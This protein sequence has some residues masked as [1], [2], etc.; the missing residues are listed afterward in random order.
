MKTHL[1]QFITS[2]ACVFAISFAFAQ[3][4]PRDLSSMIDEKA[5]YLEDDM[6]NH[7]YTYIKTSKSGY[8]SYTYWWNSSSNK[9]VTARTTG[10][11][12]ASITE[13]PGF[14]CGKSTNAANHSYTHRD[15]GY[16]ENH[17][18]DSEKEAYRYG[19]HDGQRHNSKYEGYGSNIQ[20]NAYDK[21]YRAGSN[22]DAMDAYYANDNYGHTHN[23]YSHYNGNDYTS[24]HNNAGNWYDFSRLNGM[25]ADTAY[26]TLE[27][28]GFGNTK[29]F[30]EDGVTYKLWWNSNKQQCIK[31]YS[32][33]YYIARI[34]NSNHCK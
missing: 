9:C 29:T 3:N 33:N 6:S 24:N 26:V 5:T 7:G 10:G 27:Q 16:N 8:D 25:K 13:T 4:T 18:N 22:G 12:V 21:G 31:T 23:N 32:K 17:S 2:G 34:E 14:D 20:M 30:Q 15:Y 1:K 19:Y 28:N 11:R